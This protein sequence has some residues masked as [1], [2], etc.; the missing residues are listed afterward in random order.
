MKHILKASFWDVLED[1][2]RNLCLQTTAHKSNYVLVTDIRLNDDLIC[3]IFS[4]YLIKRIGAL[5]CNMLVVVNSS[6]IDL[7]EG[8]VSKES[9][10]AICDF[11]YFLLREC[12]YTNVFQKFTTIFFESI[13]KLLL[14]MFHAQENEYDGQNCDGTYYC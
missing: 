13:F 2:H 11:A 3:K 8:T 5:H 1:Q 4:T 12:L 9:A 7:T 10:I 14:L 6:P